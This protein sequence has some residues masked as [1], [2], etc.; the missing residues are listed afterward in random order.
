[1]G[2]HPVRIHRHLI[3]PS[4]AVAD[5][6]RR[7]LHERLGRDGPRRRVL[8]DDARGAVDFRVHVEVVFPEVPLHELLVLLGVVPGEDQEVLAADEPVELLPPV[9]FA[10]FFDHFLHVHNLKRLP[11]LTLGLLNGFCARLGSS[12]SLLDQC[13]LLLVVG[14]DTLLDACFEVEVD[15]IAHL[16]LSLVFPLPILVAILLLLLLQISGLRQ[17]ECDHVLVQLQPLDGQSH[18]VVHLP[19]ARDQIADLLPVHSLCQCSQHCIPRRVRQ[20][21]VLREKLGLEYIRCSLL[22]QFLEAVLVVS[23]H[24]LY[25]GPGIRLFTLHLGHFFLHLDLRIELVHRVV[26][27]LELDEPHCLGAVVVMHCEARRDELR[28]DPAPGPGGLRPRPRLRLRRRRRVLLRALRVLPASPAAGPGGSSPSVLRSFRVLGD[29]G[30]AAAGGAGALRASTASPASPGAA[31][32]A[33]AVPDVVCPALL[34]AL[35]R[36]FLSLGL[37][38]PQGLP[39]GLAHLLLRPPVRLVLFHCGLGPAQL[40]DDVGLEGHLRR[41]SH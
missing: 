27:A 4:A 15:V 17:R 39:L 18:R 3:L 32:A 22:L 40:L 33:A 23:L 29:R 5:G 2:V 10:L 16:L 20:L 28:V 13:F 9:D 19:L 8:D 38:L 6:H 35:V 11:C 41:H 26:K 31:V 24:P 1:M 25:F 7:C 37:G 36:L 14:V 12:L 30:A 34:S 21:G